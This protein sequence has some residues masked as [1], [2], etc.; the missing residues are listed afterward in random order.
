MF[1]PSYCGSL[2]ILYDHVQF[3]TFPFFLKINFPD[4]LV[5]SLD[6]LGVNVNFTRYFNRFPLDSITDSVYLYRNLIASM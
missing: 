4:I 5:E 6:F 3:Y 1:Q 2:C